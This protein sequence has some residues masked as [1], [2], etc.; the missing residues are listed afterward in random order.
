MGVGAPPPDI[1]S[2]CPR[3]FRQPTMLKYTRRVASTATNQLPTNVRCHASWEQHSVSRYASRFMSFAV[4]PAVASHPQLLLLAFATPNN[5]LLW[6]LETRNCYYPRYFGYPVP[7]LCLRMNLYYQTTYL[8]C[9]G[10]LNHP[11]NCK[12]S[13]QSSNIFEYESHSWCA[14]HNKPRSCP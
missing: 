6:G 9:S 3:T 5:C 7:N 13:C 14:S 11:T 4:N 1:H 2:R 10:T 8:S 12:L